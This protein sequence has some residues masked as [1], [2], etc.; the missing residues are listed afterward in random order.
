MRPYAQT[1]CACQGRWSK[2]I[3]L[4]GIQEDLFT[5]EGF[6]FFRQEVQR[7]LAERRRSHNLETESQATELKEVEKEIANLLAAIKMG[8]L[9]STTKAELERLEDRRAE[10]LTKKPSAPKT[11]Q[12]IL[13][14][15]LDGFRSAITN[16]GEMSKE[17][18]AEAQRGLLSLLGGK[19]IILHPTHD[20]TLEAEL[21]GDYA[22]LVQLMG[23]QKL[24][25]LGC[26]GR[27]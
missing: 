23:G 10:L 24:N 1:G 16:L 12:N 11:V 25:N 2:E 20:G 4:R 22:G 27:I 19:P 5:V 18:V 17:H 3:L 13:P 15:V 6:A 8:I 14:R 9:T 7:L 21:A 26:G